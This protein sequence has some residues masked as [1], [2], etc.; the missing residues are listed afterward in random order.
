MPTLNALQRSF[1]SYTGLRC[2]RG[3]NLTLHLPLRCLSQTVAPN[4]N[5]GKN[6]RKNGFNKKCLKNGNKMVKMATIGK[7]G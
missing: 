5:D 7:K 1:T 4:S 6:W 3:Q 2:D